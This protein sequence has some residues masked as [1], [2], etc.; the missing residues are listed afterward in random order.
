[1]FLGEVKTAIKSGIN[2]KFGIIG[3][4]YEG[5]HFEPFSL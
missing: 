4:Y 5:R 2:S 3:F 1:M